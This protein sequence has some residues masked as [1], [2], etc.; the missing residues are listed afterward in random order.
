MMITDAA[1]VAGT[2]SIFAL[3]RRPL[4]E[5]AGDD[6]YYQID[7]FELGASRR[8]AFRRLLRRRFTIAGACLRGLTDE[9]RLITRCAA[10]V[11]TADWHGGARAEAP[12]GR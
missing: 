11:S 8:C 12:R 10:A 2:I 6:D 3:S 9:G 7:D 5:I 1:I 4:A